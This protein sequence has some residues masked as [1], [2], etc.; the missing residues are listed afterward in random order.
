MKYERTSITERKKWCW[1]VAMMVMMMLL[2]V[3]MVVV[4]VEVVVQ[5]MATRLFSRALSD[6]VVAFSSVSSSIQTI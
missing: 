6:L 3:V 2:V 1:F 4:M 5:P